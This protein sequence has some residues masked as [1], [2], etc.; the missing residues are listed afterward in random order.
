M[1]FQIVVRVGIKTNMHGVDENNF[2]NRYIWLIIIV[3]KI[4]NPSWIIG[5][6]TYFVRIKRHW[7]IC[8][9]LRMG[10]TEIVFERNSKNYNFEWGFGQCNC[11]STVFKTPHPALS[12]GEG[13]FITHL[14]LPLSHTARSLTQLA[15]LVGSASVPQGTRKLL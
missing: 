2:I 12:L 10:E 3:E 14:S 11:C 9:S 4:L 6:S 5:G 8:L 7:F 13:T 1:Q 15:L